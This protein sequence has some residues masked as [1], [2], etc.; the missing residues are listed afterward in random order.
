MPGLTIPKTSLTENPLVGFH[1]AVVFFSG[2]TGGI[3]PNPVDMRFQKVSGIG[4]D[5]K[6]KVCNNGANSDIQYLVEK[7]TYQQ[8]VLERGL[9]IGSPLNMELTVFLNDFKIRP[10]NVLVALLNDDSIPVAAW[11]FEKTY[12]VKWSISS[13]DATANTIM[14]ETMELVYSCFRMMRI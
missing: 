6:T 13:L 8:L 10:G 14:V 2:L 3:V 9:V 12:P 11:F 7:V 4:V 5:I 1:F